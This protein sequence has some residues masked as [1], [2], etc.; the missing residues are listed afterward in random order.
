MKGKT[1]VIA[2][3]LIL[4]LIVLVQNT[5]IVTVKLFFWD[6]SMSRII[7]IFL[8]M[9]IGFVVGYFLQKLRHKG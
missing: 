9:L 3:V 4:F 7:L 8:A 6:M 5:Q 2:V 1:L